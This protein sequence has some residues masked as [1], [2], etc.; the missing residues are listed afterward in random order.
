MIVKQ[1]IGRLIAVMILSLLM[2]PTSAQ[3]P[4]LVNP[5]ATQKAKDVYRYIYNLKYQGLMTGQH[6]YARTWSLHDIAIRATNSVKNSIGHYPGLWGSDFSFTDPN[7]SIAQLQDA[8][9]KMIEVAKAQADAGS[10]ITLTY[11]MVTPE[12]EE[13]QGWTNVQQAR[14]T[15]S[16][17][18]ELITPGT[19]LY[20]NWKRNMDRIIPFLQDLQDEGYAVVWRPYH[21][22]NGLF[23][24]GGGDAAKVHFN[25]LWINTYNY[26]VND[27]GLNNLIWFWSPNHFTSWNNN[28]VPDPWFPGHEYVD[29]LGI[30]DYYW[31]QSGF[32]SQG[33]YDYLVNKAQG[34]PLAIGEGFNVNMKLPDVDWM[35]EHRPEYRWFMIWDGEW[36]NDRLSNSEK[37]AALTEIYNHENAVNQDN[38]YIPALDIVDETA[39]TIPANVQSTNET[40]SQIDLT[41]D[42]STDA[43]GISGYEI[44]VDG[45]YNNFTFNL[46][47][48]VKG[49]LPET[50]YVITVKARD[51]YMNRSAE[52]APLTVTTSE[53]G[54]TPPPVTGDG[55]NFLIN[56]DFEDG[57]TGWNGDVN[58]EVRSLSWL[59]PVSGAYHLG[60]SSKDDD[61]IWQ[62]VDGL[63]PGSTYLLSG[64]L[65]LNH[66]LENEEI[67]AGVRNFGDGEVEFSRL[68]PGNPAR[69]EDEWTQY[70]IEF[71]MGA[72]NTSAE[73][74]IQKL[75]GNNWSYADAFVL[76]AASSTS[77]QDNR[78]INVKAWVYNGSLN[79][80]NAEGGDLRLLNLTGSS[81]LNAQLSS[82]SHI[83]NVSHLPAGIYIVNVLHKGRVFSSKVIN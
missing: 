32:L 21:E 80:L 12:L 74:F 19:T 9:H 20:N 38:V 3:A 35:M 18:E 45:V 33:D 6:N 62:V 82:N 27:H 72:A 2:F 7:Y 53:Q 43:N 37:R 63:T 65:R 60:I 56:G 39:P 30:D 10:I 55:T 54:T 44:F 15:M 42:A 50:E 17:Y 51:H 34:K 79:I 52:S 36:I 4:E 83:I 5:N 59:D 47:T 16:E 71:T 31:D 70:S 75:S 69:P 28:R 29:M 57:L 66:S 68:Y 46:N 23:W 41:W 8:R 78:V 1:V 67:R 13:N 48:T 58:N 73:V 11:H 24:W 25:Q 77:L 64:F 61:G 49:L 40:S 81:V 22:M 14:L 76:E 26:M